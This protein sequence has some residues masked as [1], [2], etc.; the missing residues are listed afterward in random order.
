MKRILWL[1][2]ALFMLSVAPVYAQTPTPVPAGGQTQQIIQAVEQ[3][4]V[5]AQQNQ[6][7]AYLVIM[8]ALIVVIMLLVWKRQTPENNVIVTLSQLLV[9]NDKRLDD[10]QVRIEKQ[11]TADAEFKRQWLAA[12]QALN[13]NK[14]ISNA[15]L[16]QLTKQVDANKANIDKFTHEGSLPV[17]HI[18]TNVAALVQEIELIKDISIALADMSNTNQ[19]AI[20]RALENHEAKLMAAFNTTIADLKAAIE[21]RR[22]DSQPVVIADVKPEDKVA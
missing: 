7:G 2:P 21:K 14:Q 3:S 1:L 11:E 8:G 6:V 10:N 9:K 12:L 15:L 18:E 17:Q 16:E 4:V 20:L 22:T 5:T 13:E 19:E